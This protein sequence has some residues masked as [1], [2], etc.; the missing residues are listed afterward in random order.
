MTGHP[1][2]S[3]APPTAASGLILTGERTLP[4]IPDEQYW[5]QRH[6]VA[7]RLA[8]QSIGDRVG[9]GSQVTVLDA[10]CGEGYGLAMLADAGASRVIGIDLEAAV[11]DHVCA[12]YAAA[13]H[14]IEAE[15]AEL[16]SLPYPADTADLVVS[17]QVIE[18]LYDIPSYLESLARVTRP[19]GQVW[20]ATPNRL[21]FTP[22]RDTP[23]NPFHVREFTAEELRSELTA[24][25]LQVQ[26]VVGIHH[27]DRLQALARDRGMPVPEAI[28]AAPP[29]AWDDALRAAVH[30]TRADDFVVRRDDLDASLDL[31]AIARVPDVGR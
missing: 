9:R 6:V 8:A 2:P 13:D 18:H 22:G 27:G 26:R 30:A 5:F 23:A 29:A 20:I 17:F 28:T 3:V 14:R 7:Y 10:G 4:D 1:K 16:S 31:V 11:I 21:T 15:A 12:T 19:G 24:A 25:G